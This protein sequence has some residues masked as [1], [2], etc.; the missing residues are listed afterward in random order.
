MPAGKD[1]QRAA[2]EFQQFVLGCCVCGRHVLGRHIAGRH[3]AAGPFAA[4]FVCLH[5]FTLECFYRSQSFGERD[6]NSV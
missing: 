5:E 2:N 3:V 1:H 6:G 4:V